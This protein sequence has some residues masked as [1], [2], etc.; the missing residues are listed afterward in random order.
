MRRMYPRAEF[1]SQ[2][3]QRITV[4]SEILRGVKNG[5]AYYGLGDQ[6]TNYFKEI[7]MDTQPK[8][9]Q[10]LTYGNI[11]II[12]TKVNNFADEIKNHPRVIMWESSDRTGY[13]NKIIPTN[14]RAI[15]MTRFIG[16]D[17]AVKLLKEAR[18]RGM[19][20]FHPEGTG[21][22][23]KQVRELL[24]LNKQEQKETEQPTVTTTHE[25]K[26]PQTVEE[27]I[28]EETP[29]AHSITHGQQGKLQ[30]IHKY[31]RPELTKLEA[32]RIMFA[33][34]E[35]LGIQTTLASVVQLVYVMRRKAAGEPTRTYRRGPKPS[36]VPM[37]EAKVAET[38]VVVVLLDRLVGEMR[39][40]RQYLVETVAENKKLRA[41]MDNF[42]KM[43]E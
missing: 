39:D 27:V 30:P 36:S 35:K 2:K 22:I 16:H 24:G 12:G 3:K 5:I 10:P 4:A 18:N 17:A 15:F 32:A 14:V 7:E 26:L 28:K 13:A 1:V 29:V 31:H 11:L 6:N 9:L 25:V 20:T 21:Q 37:K 34:A 33:E 43:F 40:I 19:T 38:D 42:R 41:K 8:P 23:A